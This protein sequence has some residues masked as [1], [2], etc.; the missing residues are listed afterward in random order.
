MRPPNPGTG[1]FHI[2][3]CPRFD[4]ETFDLVSLN[5]KLRLLK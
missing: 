4:P 1:L 2:D 5:R 3:E